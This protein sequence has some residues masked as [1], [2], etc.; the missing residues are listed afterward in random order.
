MG[1][2]DGKS[3]TRRRAPQCC[4]AGMEGRSYLPSSQGQPHGSPHPETPRGRPKWAGAGGT[5]PARSPGRGL[6]VPVPTLGG[7]TLNHCRLPFRIWVMRTV[8][9]GHWL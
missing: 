6:R 4:G 2:R 8:L 1:V 5:V 7:G 3:K 9:T